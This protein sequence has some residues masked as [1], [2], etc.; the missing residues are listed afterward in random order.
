MQTRIRAEMTTK[1]NFILQGIIEAD[2]TYAGGRPRKGNKRED[3]P[4][5]PEPVELKKTRV[6]DWLNEAANSWRKS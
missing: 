2:E 3:D 1:N 6:S 5:N 4:K